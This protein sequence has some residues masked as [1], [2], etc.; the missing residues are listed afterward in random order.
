MPITT[1]E[2]KQLSTA[3]EWALVQ[4]SQADRIR[5]L[6]PAR[7]KAKIGRARTLRNKY[8]DLAKRQ[9]R[10][11]QP[12]RSGGPYEALNARTGRKAEL[13]EQVLGRFEKELERQA[14]KT[15]AAPAK[16]TPKRK[17]RRT[18]RVKTPRKAWA[19]PSKV[20]S[21]RAPR[22]PKSAMPT[23]SGQRRIH[24]HLSA[25]GRR[26]QVRRDTRGR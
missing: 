26:R 8:R 20:K 4:A 12:R 19:R 10:K 2:A 15:A 3:G 6:T 16:T 9:H 18:A 17:A 5:E 7:L 25:A 22:G 24:A 23:R 21:S 1:R 11:A 13:F 14:A